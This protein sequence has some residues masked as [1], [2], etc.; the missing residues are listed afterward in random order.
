M[1]IHNPTTLNRQGNDTG[2]QYRSII[3]YEKGNKQQYEAIQKVLEEVAKEGQYPGLCLAYAV[4]LLA[5]RD[6]VLKLFAERNL[7]LKQI[8]R[9]RQYAATLKFLPIE[10]FQDTRIPTSHFREQWGQIG[11]VPCPGNSVRNLFSSP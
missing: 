4:Y 2:T 11:F 7:S 5:P 8:Q 6:R 1:H 10:S 3:I 9:Q